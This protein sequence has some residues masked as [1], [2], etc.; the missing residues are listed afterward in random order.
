[1]SI[2]QNK[3][4]NVKTS[5]VNALQSYQTGFLLLGPIIMGPAVAEPTECGP[6]QG[7]AYTEVYRGQTNV[8]NLN[9]RSR[10]VFSV[11]FPSQLKGA[12]SLITSITKWLYSKLRCIAK[13]MEELFPII[14]TYSNSIYVYKGSKYNYVSSVLEL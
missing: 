4:N 9:L 11:I 8:T 13:E 2:K 6:I 1:M 7:S 5:K 10:M 14:R 3:Q 12:C